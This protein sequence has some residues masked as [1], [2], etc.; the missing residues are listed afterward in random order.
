MATTRAASKPSRTM[1]SNAASTCSAYFTT[2]G[3][4]AEPTHVHVE[5][6]PDG[7]P[8]GD[9]RRSAVAHERQ[10]DA[11]DGHDPHGHAHV[12]EDLEHQ[13]RQHADADEHAQPVLGYL[14]CAPYPDAHEPEQGERGGA[15]HEPE[16]LPQ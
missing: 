15:A 4:S 14:G 7:D 2:Q 11:G 9:D 12:L 5:H 16:L 1:M 3:E 13:H 6:Q 8:R 10:G